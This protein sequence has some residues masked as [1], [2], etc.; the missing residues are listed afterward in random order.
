MVHPQGSPSIVDWQ[1]SLRHSRERQALSR[2]ELARLASLSVETIRAYESG[3]RKPT[4]K[5]LTA[6]LDALKLDPSWNG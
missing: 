3:R 1:E 2:A 4:L 6:I 5:S